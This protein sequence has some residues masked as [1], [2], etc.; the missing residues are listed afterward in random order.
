MEITMKVHLTSARVR[1]LPT[2]AET[3]VVWDHLAGFGVRV[4]ARSGTKTYLLQ[5]RTRKG[6]NVKMRLGR[7][8]EVS[9]EWARRRALDLVR[10]IETG[11]DPAADLKAQRNAE[12]ER[13][14]APTVALLIGEWL[15]A[16]RSGWRPST[17]ENYR[18]WADL[19][20]LPRLGARKAHELE[21]GDVRRWYREMAAAGAGA[22]TRNRALAVLSS[23][24]SWA[25]SSDDWPIAGNPCL[26]AV[27][28][29]EKAR[30]D[31][32]ERYPVDDE[33]ERL[34]GVLRDRG[35]HPAL[36]FLLLLLSGARRS[37]VWSMRWCDVD[38]DAAT[39]TKP[40]GMT[41]QRKAHRLPLSPEAVAVLGAVRADRP[42]SP[43]GS[44]GE[45]ALRRAW[46]EVCRAADLNDLRVHDLRHWHASLL[47]S[48]GLS[49]PLIGA[50][51]GHSSPATTSR[52]A[53]LLDRA[54]REATGQ[55][56][57]VVGLAGRRK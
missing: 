14:K 17:V 35:D 24:Y 9:A 6:R 23:A 40:A 15:A 39:W 3:Y 27:G 7:A 57:Q 49:L 32:R 41:K 55:L 37:E 51:L 20:V 43:F 48:A 30:E 56:G 10:E 31:R 34:V 45:S 54:L 1:A 42:F 11:G 36:F 28:R 5:R 22:A 53:H 12:R 18:R 29:R 8:N 50:L 4:M 16:N 2:T 44:L 13:R 19:H 25:K 46:V 47:A 38:L 52:Y 33:L 26:G 21:P